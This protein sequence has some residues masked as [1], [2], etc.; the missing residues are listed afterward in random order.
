L[1][2]SL[3]S[4]LGVMTCRVRT[5]IAP[6]HGEPRIASAL[7][8][9]RVA[10]QLVTVIDVCEAWRHV[11]GDDGYEGWMHEGYLEA[12][13]DPDAGWP[14][15]MGAQVRE[16]DGRVR[17]LP[18]GARVSP[19]ATVLRGELLTDRERAQRYPAERDAICRSA[20]SCF[21]GASYVWGA[22]TP[23]GCDCSG[24]VQAVY[25]WHGVPLP[26]DAWQQALVGEAIPIESAQPADLL[27]FSDRDDARIT[28]VAV[29][30]TAN[31]LVHSALARGGVYV[32]SLGT[33][34]P[35]VRRLHRQCVGARRVV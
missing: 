9:Q 28:H 6:M 4:T 7:T 3:Q 11:R 33:D 16:V 31:R 27:F 26:R 19:H 21:A 15:T 25:G 1:S 2:D 18:F 30:L 35:Y 22:V 20:E 24:F 23:W 12:A 32:E 13:A 5:P 34:D 10:G 8:S 14:A 17:E 29:V